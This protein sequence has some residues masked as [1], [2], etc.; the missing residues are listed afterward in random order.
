[1]AEVFPDLFDN[2]ECEYALGVRSLACLD[3]PD[4][5]AYAF[6]L[7]PFLLNKL[8]LV[9][10]NDVH[11]ALLQLDISFLLLRTHYLL[12][13]VHPL[14]LIVNSLE[15]RRTLLDILAHER[16]LRTAHHLLVLEHLLKLI[17]GLLCTCLQVVLIFYS[18]RGVRGRTA[19]IVLAL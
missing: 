14:R 8:P 15:V 11:L 12:A 5:V 2:M 16:K 3:H 10:V 17:Q 13:Q 9:Y 6:H 4:I 1:V 19:G 18:L 7:L